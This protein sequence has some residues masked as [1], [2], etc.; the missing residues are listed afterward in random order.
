MKI[1]GKDIAIVA[2]F[3]VIGLLSRTAYHLGP[4]IEFITALSVVSPFFLSNK[5]LSFLVPFGSMILSDLMLGNTIIFTFTW[6]AFLMA[7]VFG[8]I[9]AK[10][11]RKQDFGLKAL[12][13][14]GGSLLSNIVFFLWTNFGV[15]ITTTMYDKNLA[16]LMQSYINALPFFR[17][18]LISGL[19]F[20][21]AIMISIYALTKINERLRSESLKSIQLESTGF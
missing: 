5:K 20:T 3:I 14:T 2:V 17:N 11:S 15:V 16:G 21:P 18:Q 4:N 12:T 1:K 7:P 9:A 6:S 19:I 10:I 8:I 13:S